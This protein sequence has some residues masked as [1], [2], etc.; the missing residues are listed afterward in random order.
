MDYPL[1]TKKK[2]TTDFTMDW[3]GNLPDP[4]IIINS[5][6]SISNGDKQ[7]LNEQIRSRYKDNSYNRYHLFNIGT[8]IEF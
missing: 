5:S 6:D 7:I 1:T 3:F 8:Q 2:L 4:N